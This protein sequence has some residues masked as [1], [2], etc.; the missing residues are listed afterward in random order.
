MGNK[1]YCCEILRKPNISEIKK[2]EI[3]LNVLGSMLTLE[4]SLDKIR[5][6]LF[7]NELIFTL[8]VY[9]N[10][11]YCFLLE[12]KEIINHASDI[13]YISNKFIKNLESILGD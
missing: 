7:P 4:R 8:A 3:I 11:I 12:S 1:E 10:A 13:F 9:L 5:C 6:Y 2:Q